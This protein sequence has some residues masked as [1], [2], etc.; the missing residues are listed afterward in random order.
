MHFFKRWWPRRPK[1]PEGPT[2]DDIDAAVSYYEGLY[3]ERLPDPQAFRRLLQEHGVP[4]WP[5]P[6]ALSDPA[7]YRLHPDGFLMADLEEILL[8]MVEQ[9]GQDPATPALHSDLSAIETA[10]L[11]VRL[12]DQ[13]F[14]RQSRDLA[15]HCWALL[16][17]AGKPAPRLTSIVH[18]DNLWL[19]NMDILQQA[20]QGTWP[21]IDPSQVAQGMR[22]LLPSR[23]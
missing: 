23:S 18:P 2:T 8:D 17:S 1:R 15:R 9:R 16:L 20:M 21:D 5:N 14:T 3:R 12:D 10:A 6:Y 19:V 13:Q 22:Q 11:R 4:D 7:H